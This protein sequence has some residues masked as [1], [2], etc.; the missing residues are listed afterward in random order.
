[1]SRRTLPMTTLAAGDL[2]TIDLRGRAID[3]VHQWAGEVI[4][5][6]GVAIRLRTCWYRIGLSACPSESERVI[7][8]ARIDNVRL[9]PAS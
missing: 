1:M 7:P 4:A 9:E 8:W 5:V 6:D 2:V 3:R